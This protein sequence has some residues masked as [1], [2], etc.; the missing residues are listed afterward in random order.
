MKTELHPYL[1][2]NIVFSMFFNIPGEGIVAEFDNGN[3]AV[4]YDIKGLQYR[5]IERKKHQL[6]THEEEKVLAHLYEL[7]QA[8]SVTASIPGLM[9]RYGSSD[10]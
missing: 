1:K 3:E 5:I 7:N 6:E 4:L 10:Q 2:K 9:E 8:Q